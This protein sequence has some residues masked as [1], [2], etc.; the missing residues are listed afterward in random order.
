[1]PNN[2]RRPND[3][4][5]TLHRYNRGDVEDTSPSLIVRLQNREDLA[6]ETFVK[7]YSKLVRAWCRRAN[8]KLPE[9]LLRDERKDIASEVIAKAA[10]KLCD[11]N[12]EPIKNLRAWLYRITENCIFDFLRQRKKRIWQLMSDTGY[13][14]NRSQ[15]EVSLDVSDEQEDKLIILKEIIERIKPKIKGEHWAVYQ[16][17]VVEGKDSEEVAKLLNMTGANVR[18]I[19]SRV[20][21]R[22]RQEYARLGMEDEQPE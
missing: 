19:K 14:E 20:L 8:R 12:T 18:Q 6:T 13:F 9:P 4:D 11:N 17:T 15:H 5:S 1:M 22:I 2:L 7:M 3:D 10:R 21:Q 16:H